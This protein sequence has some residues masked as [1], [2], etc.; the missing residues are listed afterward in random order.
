MIGDRRKYQR[1]KNLMAA[2]VA[3][4]GRPQRLVSTDVSP[5]GA[6]F[7]TTDSPEVGTSLEVHL[8]PAGMK[9]PP[10]RLTAEVVRVVQG[11]GPDQ[12]GFGVRWAEAHCEVGGEALYDFLR[13]VLKLPSLSR[14][15]IGHDR[16]LNYEFP[17]VGGEFPPA[18]RIPEGGPPLIK[19]GRTEP[20]AEPSGSRSSTAKV[21]SDT[22]AGRHRQGQITARPPGSSPSTLRPDLGPFGA[23]DRDQVIEPTNPPAQRPGPATSSAPATSG[24]K[25]AAATTARG[26]PQSLAL[27]GPWQPVP[28][29]EGSP[30]TGN[31]SFPTRRNSGV[32]QAEN[33]MVGAPIRRK[34]DEVDRLDHRRQVSGASRAPDVEARSGRFIGIPKADNV[35]AERVMP[36]LDSGGRRPS[37]RG[38]AA[39]QSGAHSPFQERSL[40]FGGGP[41]SSIGGPSVAGTQG[42]REEPAA[43]GSVKVDIPIT[44]EMDNRF[45]VGQVV[46]AAPLAVEIR[47]SDQA[48]QFEQSLVVNMPIEIDKAFTTVYL[49]GKLLRVP[50]HDDRGSVF[51]LH[52]ERVI[53]GKNEGAYGRF[54]AGV[55]EG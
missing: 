48:P 50:E 19:R 18:R 37:R 27:S 26:R 32:I 25:P 13:H 54:L 39:R 30:R 6:F 36:D 11:G 3:I 8:R 4:S 53:E 17:T 9:V 21:I 16:T 33:V 15:Q 43:Q 14:D 12:P 55:H 45:A 2:R 10:V 7:A 46:A 1:Q 22:I 40:I 23:S 24:T 52:I 41:M 29:A 49:V 51:V 28:A 20:G 47:T 38:S 34:G 31:R 5:T 35:R 44:Y 42:A